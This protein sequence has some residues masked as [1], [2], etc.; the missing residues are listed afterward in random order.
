[1]KR[2]LVTRRRELTR[3]V[4]SLV[5][6]RLR[7]N[8]S[9]HPILAN[10][11][12]KAGTHLLTSCLSLLPG[13]TDS[14]LRGRG[15]VVDRRL[16]TQL[17]MVGGGC[18][19]PMHLTFSD[20]RA[21][22][23]SDV[24]FKMV[25]IIRDPRDIVVSHFHYVSYRSRRH[26]LHAYYT[27]LPDDQTRLMVSITG[28][29]EPQNDPIVRLPDIDSRSRAFLTWKDHGA[30]VVKFENLVGPHGGGTSEAQE[31]EICTLAEYLGVDYSEETIKHIARNVYD[32]QS[33]TFRKGST[34]D[35]KNHLTREHKEAFKQIAGQLIV[36]LG[37]EQDQEW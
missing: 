19:M 24:G 11:I 7:A 35:W 26:R 29:L 27:S 6:R 30:C 4:R 36:D 17:R 33:A 12:P 34:G 10:S 28:I 3:S 20:E 25:L 18:F 13:I 8:A 37:Y 22:L 1:M 14:G 2:L 21:Q 31:K 15:Q 9:G 16:E 32:P 5:V 23:L